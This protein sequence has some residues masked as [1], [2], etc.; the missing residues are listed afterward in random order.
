[1]LRNLFGISLYFNALV[2]LLVHFFLHHIAIGLIKVFI[3]QNYEFSMPPPHAVLNP[4]P[5][6]Q[7]TLMNALESNGI[8]KAFAFWDLRSLS[9]ACHRRRQIIFSLSQPGGHPRN[10]RAIKLSCL[11]HIERLSLQFENENDRIRSE[12]F[13]SVVCFL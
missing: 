2:L 4:T 6:E 12:T 1:L 3:L 10:W 8:I 13:A 9:A 5:E 7:R 11:R